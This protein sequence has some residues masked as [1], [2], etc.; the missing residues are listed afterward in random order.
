ML[1]RSNF[2]MLC[3][4]RYTDFPQFFIDIFHE[5][6]DSLTNG[7]KIVIIQFLAFWRHS[8]EQCTSCVDQILSLK[9]FLSIHKEIFLLRSNGRCYLLGCCISKETDQSDRLFTDCLHRTKQW[10]L[11]IQ[12]FSF[13]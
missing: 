6:C 11:L 2:V 1:C 9:E 4:G 8:T 5:T 13:I 7:S 10:C 12:R 3:L